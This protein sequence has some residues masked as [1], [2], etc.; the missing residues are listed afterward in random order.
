MRLNR[1]F[2]KII[3]VVKSLDCDQPFCD[4]MDCSLSGSSIHGILQ[5]R[6]LEWLPFPFPGNLLDPGIKPCSPALQVDSLL[7]EL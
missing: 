7:T 5:A 6:I 1:V 3:S 2:Y 4:P